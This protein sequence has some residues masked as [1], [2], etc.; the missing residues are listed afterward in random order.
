MLPHASSTAATSITAIAALM[1]RRRSTR[2]ASC[3]EGMVN[4]TVGTN[5]SK[6]T[7]P[8]SHA[9]AVRSYICQ[10]SATSRIWFAAVESMRV[11]RKKWKLRDN[12]PAES[13]A[14]AEALIAKNLSQRPTR[15]THVTPRGAGRPRVG[16]RLFTY[17]L[18]PR[19]VFRKLQPK[20]GHIAFMKVRKLRE[21]DFHEAVLIS[22]ADQLSCTLPDGLLRGERSRP[23]DF[24]D[25]LR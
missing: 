25:H 5:C 10:P 1:T 2:S 18:L 11:H 8:R 23:Y 7:S 24:A 13:G 21:R 15:P 12:G 19:L 3:P 14:P 20:S 16:R 17:R 4:A 9:L 22:L 6:P